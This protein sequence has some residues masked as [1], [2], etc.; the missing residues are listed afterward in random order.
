MLIGVIVG[1]GIGWGAGWLGVFLG[2]IGAFI[3]AT[4]PPSDNALILPP[5][6]S[7][8]MAGLIIA[9]IIKIAKMGNRFTEHVKEFLRNL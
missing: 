5:G 7:G 3:D 8:Y 1:A 9:F 6:L 2:L 4:T